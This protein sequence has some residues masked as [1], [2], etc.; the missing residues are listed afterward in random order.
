MT[1]GMEL[2]HKKTGWVVILPGPFF[3]SSIKPLGQIPV[4]SA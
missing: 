2:T 4:S 3:V 1:G